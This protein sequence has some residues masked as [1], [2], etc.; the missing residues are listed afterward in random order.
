[1]A[2]YVK[3]PEVDQMAERLSRI[4]RISK[5]EAVR[6]ALRREL[7]QVETPSDFVERGVAF[8]RALIA[9][10]DREGG[11]PVDKAW[12]DGLYEES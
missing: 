9:R 4:G 5:T 12:I 11:Q 10:G 8:T 2:L 3:D 6:R 7:D 1:M